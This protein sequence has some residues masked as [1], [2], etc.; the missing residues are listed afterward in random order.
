MKIY[1]VEMKVQL[2]KP[3]H[4]EITLQ[5]YWCMKQQAII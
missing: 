4:I 1:D 5:F 3:L 2:L